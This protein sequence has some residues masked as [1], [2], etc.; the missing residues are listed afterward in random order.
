MSK[1]FTIKKSD[2]TVID[3][4]VFTEGSILR[5]DSVFAI[6]PSKTGT[7]MLKIYAHVGNGKRTLALVQEYA[8]RTF[9]EPK[10]NVD[11]VNND[12]SIHRMKVVAQG[13]VNVPKTNDPDLKRVSHPVLSFQMQTSGRGTMDTLKAIGNRMTFEMRDRIDKMQDGNVIQISNIKYLLDGDTFII[14]EPLRVYLINDK[15][16]KF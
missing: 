4:I 6:K 15:I 11:G 10:P 8:V 5:K 14:R 1:K 9:A 7:G 3:T 12:S 2:A 16:N 13:Y